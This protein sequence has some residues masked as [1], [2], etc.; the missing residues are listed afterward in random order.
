MNTEQLAQA[1]KAIKNKYFITHLPE[2]VKKEAREL[3]QA[4][5]QNMTYSEFV[6]NM[7]LGLYNPDQLRA[8]ILDGTVMYEGKPYYSLP[9]KH[10]IWALLDQ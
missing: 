7:D 10:A 8:I 6:D 1:A 9:A 5:G 3:H 4:I 2:S